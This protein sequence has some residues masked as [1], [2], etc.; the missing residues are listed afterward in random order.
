MGV[1]MQK[2]AKYLIIGIVLCV[3]IMATGVA[4][5]NYEK[6]NRIARFVQECEKT[7][8]AEDRVWMPP[9]VPKKGEGLFDPSTA[10]RV[11]ECDPEKINGLS[12]RRLE[13]HSIYLAYSDTQRIST[14]F[15]FFGLI[16]LGFF[17][18]PLIWYFL[19]RRIVELRN[20]ITGKHD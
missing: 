11:L 12:K 7:K 20:A 8:A 3:G 9:D 1:R 16:V 6:S 14:E 17:S 18:A 15:F 2:P 19:L 4:L 5:K 10:I 13:E